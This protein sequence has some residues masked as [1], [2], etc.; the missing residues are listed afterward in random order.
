MSTIASVRYD[1]DMQKSY[2][3]SKDIQGS[4]TVITNEEGECEQSY[5]YTDYGETTNNIDTNF[6]NEI[7]YT[8]GVYDEFT[9]LYYLNARYYDS[10]SG[11]F[12]SQDTYRGTEADE[13]SWNLYGYCAGNPVS[14]VDPSGHYAAA[15]PL[16]SYGAVNWWNPSGWIALGAA[17]VI[18]GA[19]MYVTYE[20]T[21]YIVENS[22]NSS[23]THS[24][25][26]AKIS[27]K[28]SN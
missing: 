4:T 17:V 5:S 11:C 9:G 24:K 28:K 3:Y 25:S 22:S 6:Y 7:C 1:G 18:T 2:F 15:V 10:E 12:I 8:G 21:K 16:C 27:L 13:N 23:N 26:K 19:T 14:Y 20:G